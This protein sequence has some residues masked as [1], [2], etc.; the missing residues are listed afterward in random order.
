MPHFPGKRPG[1]N[2]AQGQGPSARDQVPAEPPT[3]LDITS[4]FNPSWAFRRLTVVPQQPCPLPELHQGWGFLPQEAEL[5]RNIQEL[6]KRT[7][8]QAVNQIRWVSSRQD[9]PCPPP[10]RRALSRKSGRPE[11]QRGGALPQVTARS[12][13]W[14]GAPG[15][16][17]SSRFLHGLGDLGVHTAQA[18]L[19]E[20][21]GQLLLD[22]TG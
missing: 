9:D 15:G 6:L 16:C 18:S 2:K 17:G 22:T 19:L 11:A 1:G 20:R 14:A 4:S 13:G 8:M 21:K 7:I 5:I 3:P 12:A 10:V